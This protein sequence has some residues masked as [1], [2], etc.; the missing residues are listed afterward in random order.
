M[1][2]HDR[3]PKQELVDVKAELR[4]R[5]TALKSDSLKAATASLAEAKFNSV[6]KNTKRTSLADRLILLAEKVPEGTIT[7]REN[8]EKLVKRFETLEEEHLPRFY[9]IEAFILS[10]SRE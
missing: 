3:A 10:N 4:A 9:V 8:F 7:S 2:T 1:R 6:V 5:S